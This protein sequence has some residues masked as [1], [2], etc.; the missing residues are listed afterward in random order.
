MRTVSCRPTS[1]CCSVANK[2]RYGTATAC[3][4]LA[5]TDGNP[6]DDHNEASISRA[7]NGS[8]Q[9]R[10][11]TFGDIGYRLLTGRVTGA[12]AGQKLSNSFHPG[13]PGPPPPII[14]PATSDQLCWF[15]AAAAEYINTPCGPAT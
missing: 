9:R 5:L 6:V 2:V 4:A 3:A 15:S 10:N 7:R 12:V 14:S 8:S 11:G 13:N 1:S